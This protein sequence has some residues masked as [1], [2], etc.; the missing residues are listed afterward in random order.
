M[1]ETK[2]A[3]T[4]PALLSLYESD[5][6]RWTEMMAAR[7]RDREAGALG[8]ENLAEEIESSGR[9][10]RRELKSRL[11]VLIVHLLKLQYQPELREESTWKATIHEQRVQIAY[12]LEDSPS[13]RRH[14][15]E[16]WAKVHRD[17]ARL[18][19]IEMKT[20][21]PLPQNLSLHSGPST[22]LRLLP[23][24]SLDPDPIITN[25]LSQL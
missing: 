22:R 25:T 9:R 1:A 18:A 14:I 24:V 15:R 8:W 10:D 5:F 6:Y 20:E 21:R 13:L 7:L 16:A 17:A 12:V 11:T 3:E 4:D 2:L 23:G 19:R